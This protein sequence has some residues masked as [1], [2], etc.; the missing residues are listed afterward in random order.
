MAAVV[1][2]GADPV[3]AAR[4]APLASRVVLEQHPDAPGRAAR[5]EIGVAHAADQGDG[6]RGQG[7]EGA[8][9]LVD[10]H[11]VTRVCTGGR[12]GGSPVL[13][14]GGKQLTDRVTQSPRRLELVVAQRG[15]GARQR[16]FREPLAEGPR[17]GEMVD[18]AGVAVVTGVGE[19]EAVL[20][21]ADDPER[22]DTCS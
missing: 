3:A 11:R 9:R 17:A 14:P 4:R 2:G 10:T 15:L 13:D 8:L 7:G 6:V 16:A 18:H 22:Q 19:R 20:T 12:R 1:A 5:D 21:F